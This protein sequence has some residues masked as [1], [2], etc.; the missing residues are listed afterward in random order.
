MKSFDGEFGHVVGCKQLGIRFEIGVIYFVDY[1]KNAELQGSVI[2]FIDVFKRNSGL[3]NMLF[4]YNF[5]VIK[6]RTVAA[7][8]SDSKLRME[9]ERGVNLI[10]P[11]PPS[12]DERKLFIYKLDDGCDVDT[13]MSNYIIEADNYFSNVLRSKFA[14]SIVKN[15]KKALDIFDG[16]EN[17]SSTRNS[18]LPGFP[19][20]LFGLPDF[21][22][23]DTSLAALAPG[24]ASEEDK[25]DAIDFLLHTLKELSKGH[26]EYRPKLNAFLEG[27]GSYRLAVLIIG[28]LNRYGYEVS[29]KDI[30]YVVDLLF[31]NNR[32]KTNVFLVNKNDTKGNSGYYV[33]T[34]KNEAFKNDI[35]VGF[36]N[37]ESAVIYI[38]LLMA[39]LK[40]KNV[41]VR[42][43]LEKNKST[44]LKVMKKVYD[45]PDDVSE[46][47][48]KKLIFRKLKDNTISK[49]ESKLNI[50]RS[51]INRE[52]HET[53]VDI[54]SPFPFMIDH[55]TGHLSM[56]KANI[57]LPEFFK[58]LPIV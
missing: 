46:K 43:L 52:I 26:V 6:G 11:V 51:D 24:E 29:E 17:V 40:S 21:I 22:Y 27:L 28:L 33:V 25:K 15:P 44:F 37:K 2:H 50:C 47:R 32:V 8:K 16:H 4:H 5:K 35:S 18:F 20:L 34:F 14:G 31:G 55:V 56:P 41:D 42:I 10:T 13:E 49:K 54:D 58:E 19:S 57:D 1:K 53:L 38:M 3:N 45:L 23:G 48:Y 12:G 30:L 9:L 39:R 7:L 36:K